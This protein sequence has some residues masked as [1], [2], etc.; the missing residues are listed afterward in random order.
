M[1]KKFGRASEAI[2]FETNAIARNTVQ[3]SKKKALRMKKSSWWK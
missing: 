3:A 2:D 1:N